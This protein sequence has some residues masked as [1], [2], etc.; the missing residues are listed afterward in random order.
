MA[1]EL[2]SDT[3][4]VDGIASFPKLGETDDNGRYTI[5]VLLDKDSA[6]AKKIAQTI[7]QLKTERF[8]D[9][10]GLRV[11]LVDGDE[12]LASMDPEKRG[13]YSMYEGRYILKC[14]TTKRF[15][16]VGATSQPIS[17]DEVV[18]GNEVKVAVRF[19]TYSNKATG[20]SAFLQGVQKTGVGEPFGSGGDVQFAPV[21]Q[22]LVPETADT[23][24]DIP[25]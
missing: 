14:A 6:Q 5:G 15:T 11:P 4:F 9:R 17:P 25:F 1:K 16:L 2:Y 24:A 8:G 12:K 3:V 13:N 21:E 23:S 20:V 22:P 7:E 10:Q 18:G 19:G